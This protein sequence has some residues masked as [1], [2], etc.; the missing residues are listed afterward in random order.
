MFLQ[1]SGDVKIWVDLFT[2]LAVKLH[3][4]QKNWIAK[5]YI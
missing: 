4:I 3:T 1:I 5:I 2:S